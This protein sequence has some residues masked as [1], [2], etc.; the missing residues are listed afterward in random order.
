MTRRGCGQDAS[1]VTVAVG[2]ALST[3]PQNQQTRSLQICRTKD[4]LNHEAN[5]G[6]TEAWNSSLAEAAEAEDAGLVV[7]AGRFE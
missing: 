2:V 1:D 7:E 5:A 4:V 6:M 3:S